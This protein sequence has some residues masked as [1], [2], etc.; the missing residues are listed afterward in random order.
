MKLR[1]YNKKPMNQTVP[2]TAAL[3]QASFIR[4]EVITIK[5]I[6]SVNLRT[7]MNKPVIKLIQKE[8]LIS[9]NDWTSVGTK[10]LLI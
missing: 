4:R 6:A 9:S 1:H 2:P 5:T 7:I 8:N 10:I 3:L